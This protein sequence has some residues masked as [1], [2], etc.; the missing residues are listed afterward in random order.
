PANSP[1]DMKAYTEKAFAVETISEDLKNEL[2][3][4]FIAELD[5]KPVGYAKVKQNSQIECVKAKKPIE[6]CRLYLLE[7]YIGK[8]FGG[9]LMRHCLEFAIENGHD[10]M[11]LGVWEY[12]YRAQGFYKKFGFRRV[13]EHIFQLG[14]DPQIDW[15]LQKELS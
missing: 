9:K 6:L 15:V 12:N 14:S 13:G 8:G 3:H 11:W 10:V 7:E 1:E 5:G 4:Y 2:V